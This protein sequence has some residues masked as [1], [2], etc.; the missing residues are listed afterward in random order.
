MLVKSTGAGFTDNK[1]GMDEQSWAFMDV[2]KKDKVL[3]CTS[4]HAVKRPH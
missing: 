1:K 3:D 4:E 2:K